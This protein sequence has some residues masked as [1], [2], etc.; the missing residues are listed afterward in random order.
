M[1]FFKFTVKLVL[2]GLVIGVLS[3]QTSVCFGAVRTKIVLNANWT[4]N[5]GDVTGAEATGFNDATWT[6]V[7]LPHV[8]DTPYF[9]SSKKGVFWYVGYGW[10]RKHFN[11]QAD[12]KASKRIVLEFEAAFQVAQVYVNGKLAGEHK[13]GFTGFYFDITDAVN[14]GDNVIAVRVNNLWNA[15][16]APRA[17]DWLFLGG[18]HRD[19]YLVVTNPLHVTWYGTF[20]TTPQATASAATVRVKTEVKNE[21]AAAATCKVTTTIVDATNATVT[22]MESTQSIAAGATYEFAQTSQSIANP[23]LWSVETPSMYKVL[24]SVS[25]GSG[26]VDNYESPLG[27]RSIQWT[28]AQGFF[29]NGAHV[30][31]NGINA[32]DDRAGWGI[33]QTNAGFRRDVKLMKEAGFNLIS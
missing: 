7:N 3:A 10:Y 1:G 32:H 22:S 2:I 12:W 17:G 28:A 15:Q 24:T 8:F 21:N 13:G 33:A 19:V 27:I 25:D 11:V 20:V 29:L 26:V 14:A 23:H 31:I 9:A 30:L 5:K 18:I 4:F 16:I 6:K